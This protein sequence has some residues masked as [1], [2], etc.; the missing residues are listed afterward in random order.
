MSSA[1]PRRQ[2]KA[3]GA[4]EK[5]AQALAELKRCKETGIMRVSQYEASTNEM[6]A[7]ERVQ[8]QKKAQSHTND[9]FIVGDDGYREADDDGFYY[10][11]E[12]GPQWTGKRKPIDAML[13]G[14]KLPAMMMNNE[15]RSKTRQ[16][17]NSSK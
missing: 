10:S 11:D 3:V 13:R 12:E 6:L 9:D 15:P 5:K 8:I 14:N 2:V 7:E 4:S 17:R 16:E 1:R